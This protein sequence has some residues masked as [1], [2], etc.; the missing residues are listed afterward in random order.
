[1]AD[2][3]ILD[4]STKQVVR[5]GANWAPSITYPTLHGRHSGFA[6][7]LWMDGHA[8]AHKP[9][10]RTSGSQGSVTFTDWER[11]QIG[12]LIYPQYPKGSA[13]QD[14]YYLLTKP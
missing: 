7:V 4:S 5:F 11:A 8:K 1:M 13:N 6:N 3:A 10:F 12:D 2:T 14:Y 9:T